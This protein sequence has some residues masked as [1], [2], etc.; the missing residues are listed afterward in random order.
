MSDQQPKKTGMTIREYSRHIGIGANMLR[1]IIK[2]H[3]D[4]FPMTRVGNR[5]IV[6]V[7]AADAWIFSQRQ[8]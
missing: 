1:R 4:E 6:D 5:V 7:Q 2:E 3:E 8:L